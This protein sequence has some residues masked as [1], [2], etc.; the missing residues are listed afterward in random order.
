MKNVKDVV[1]VLDAQFSLT[2]LEFLNLSNLNIVRMMWQPPIQISATIIF[3]FLAL[4]FN[5]YFFSIV[6]FFLLMMQETL[7][8]NIGY[9]MLLDQAQ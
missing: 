7:P 9:P 6:S 2:R 3:Y 8:N 4:G 5:Y 1:V